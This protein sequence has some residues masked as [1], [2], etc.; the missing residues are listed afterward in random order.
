MLFLPLLWVLPSPTSLSPANSA[1][2]AAIEEGLID[3]YPTQCLVHD[4]LCCWLI[5]STVIS[6]TV[7]TKY[8]P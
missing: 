1:E 2:V 8:I 6:R 4:G 3:V 5:H 7:T